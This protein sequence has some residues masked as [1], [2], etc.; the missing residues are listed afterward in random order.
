MAFEVRITVSLSP[1]DLAKFRRLIPKRSRIR[2]A[3]ADVE[4][5]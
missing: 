5:S 1:D 4:L 3:I 2:P